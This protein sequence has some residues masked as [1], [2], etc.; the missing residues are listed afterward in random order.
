MVE[1]LVEAI[2]G[3]PD[4]VASP[5]AEPNPLILSLRIEAQCLVAFVTNGAAVFR[6]GMTPLAAGQVV[7]DG[8]LQ[9]AGRATPAG[10]GG[11]SL[12][13]ELL[14]AAVVDVLR[15]S[16]PRPMRLQLGLALDELDWE[17]FGIGAQP[18]GL[19]FAISR[20]VLDDDCW[21]RPKTEPFLR[22]VPTQN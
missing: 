19:K 14:P 22:V 1:R 18:L 20:H 15:A 9:I 2:P 13:D 21:R 12:L 17:A 6:Q 11:Q 8:C 3:L 4:M 7:Q 10:M 5:A 16:P